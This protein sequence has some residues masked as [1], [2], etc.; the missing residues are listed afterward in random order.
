MK[1]GLVILLNGTSSSGK[2]TIANALQE[3]LSEPY[4]YVSIDNYFSRYAE[5]ILD[6]TSQEDA[7]ALAGLIPDVISDFHRSVASLAQSGNNILVDHVLQEKEWLQECV[8]SWK[9]LEV[10]F[11]GIK[12]PLEV[13]EQREKERGDREIGTARYQF[14]R[15]HIHDL[16]DIEVDTSIFSADECMTSIVELINHKPTKFAFQELYARFMIDG[17]TVPNTQES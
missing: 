17:S 8:K 10:I 2:T 7:A 6:P 12:C 14:Q 3:K 15:V 9:G 13:V 4:V 5:K 1:T 11:V 16:Y